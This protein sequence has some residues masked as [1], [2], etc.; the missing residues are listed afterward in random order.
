MSEQ[1]RSWRE[2]E[3]DG[4][5]PAETEAGAM[6]ERELLTGLHSMAYY[7]C[8]NNHNCLLSPGTANSSLCHPTSI[9]KQGKS[10]TDLLTG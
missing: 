1:G 3:E 2:K 9:I 5:T 6:E 8:F 10:S 7:M 4:K